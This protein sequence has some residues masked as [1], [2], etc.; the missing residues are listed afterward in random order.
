MGVAIPGG[1][2]VEDR[3]SGALVVDGSLRFDSSKSNYLNRT[4]GSAGNLKTFTWAAWVKRSGLG[5]QQ[6]LFGV[7]SSSP[8]NIFGFNNGDKLR[9]E[10]NNAATGVDVA[11][12]AVFRDTS[13][14]YHIVLSVDTTQATASNRV[15]IYVNGV[16]QSFS[17]TSYPGQNE[18]FLIG[19]TK[20]NTFGN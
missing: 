12:A 19:S 16:A 18:D 17:S 14:W 1:G 13:A 15:K 8:Y 9:L 11:T 5:I 2:F 20:Q 3:A 10:G 4:P 7:S 6:A